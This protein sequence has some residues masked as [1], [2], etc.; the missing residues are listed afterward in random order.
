[1]KRKT[2][3]KEIWRSITHS[4]GRVLAIFGIVALGAGFLAGLSAASPTMKLTADLY[5][6]ETNYMDIRILSTL[7][8]TDEDIEALEAVQGVRA[9]MPSHQ[10]DLMVTVSQ[11]ENERVVRFA[12]LPDKMNEV[13]L[14]SGRLPE[15]E[16]ECV[17]NA[18]KLGAGGIQL[19]DEL[20]VL[21]D[22]LRH[23]TY[24]VVGLVNSAQYLSMSL[25]TT[26]KGNG[27]LNYIAYLLEGEF[28]QDVYTVAYVQAADTEGLSAFSEEYDAAIQ[29]I[30][31]ELEAVGEDRAQLRYDEMLS[32]AEDA[33][34]EAEDAYREEKEKAEKELA[35][36][37]EE[38][39][40]HEAD[41]AAGEE[42][43]AE[44]L[45]QIQDGSES[46]EEAW[47]LYRSGMADLK[48]SK[49]SGEAQFA[50]A[51]K[52]LV[53]SA[54]ELAEKKAEWEAQG[55]V[56]EAGAKELADAQAQ[57]AAAEQLLQEKSSELEEMRVM[58]DE[59]YQALEAMKGLIPDEEYEAQYAQWEAQANAFY[60]GQQEV[61][62]QHV[63]LQGQKAVLDAKAKELAEGQATYEVAGQQLAQAEEE[64]AAGQKELAAQKQN[65]AAQ[66]AAAERQLAEL[67]QTL[68]SNEEK[69]EESREKI[70]SSQ[71]EL[72]DARRQIK[73]GWKE[74]D[75]ARAEAD[76]AL[77]EAWEEIE[78]GRES[79]QDIPEPQWYV[80]DRNMDESFVSFSN[81]AE[82]MGTIATVFPWMFFIVAALV[83][84]TT[85]TRMVEEERQLIG[86]YK[87]LGFSTGWI[88]M[89]Y[90]IYAGAASL[91]GAVIGVIVGF[92]VLPR[93]VCS[94]YG[95]MYMLPKTE[96]RFYLGRA[97]IAGGTALL[98]TLLA[99]TSACLHSLKSK[100]AKLMQP[101][102]PKAG[103][104]I[105][106]ER[107]GPLWRHM[108]FIRKVTA[109]NL[110]R[111]K[112]RLFMTV[113]GIAGC[114]GL[115]VTGFGLKD[116]VMD[117]VENQ[118]H[119]V[120]AYD[121]MLGITDEAASRESLK[122][123]DMVGEYLY[124]YG[125]MAEIQSDTGSISA[126]LYVPEDEER[127][128][129]FINFRTRVGSHPVTFDSDH[130][131]ITEKMADRLEVAIGD[132]IK[133]QDVNGY[134]KAFIVGGITENY[135]QNY[136][137]LPR[138]YYEEDLGYELT[139]NQA[140]FKLADKGTDEPV[141]ELL[142]DRLKDAEGIST[143]QLLEDIIEPIEKMIQSLNLVVMVLI[144]SAGMLAFIVLYNLTN[145][146]ITERQREIATIKV[147]G[148]HP[149]EVGAYI[150]RETLA[151]TFIGCAIGL[152]FGIFMHRFVTTTVEVDMVMFGRTVHAI[153][154]LWSAIVTILFSV[155]V[156]FVMYFKL[157]KINMVESLKSVD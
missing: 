74:L 154:F 98:C 11:Q 26:T 8:L 55:P 16:D 67:Q 113:I 28:D 129:E 1:M 102:A 148:F 23:K 121:G 111:Y 131:V 114:T 76:E 45:Q 41:L 24:T 150:Y 64:L 30:V 97:I 14:L 122:N 78:K 31:D 44:G 21:E 82:R 142:R 50:A 72:E 110:F 58:L 141:G 119:K 79:L 61:A 17:V 29:V 96:I 75:K 62:K 93:V 12:G 20:T 125:R 95:L 140:L 124:V 87:A 66:I 81:D 136:V 73:D 4:M 51:E 139:Y 144:I 132:E 143:V 133:L 54:A 53:D 108:S 47:E 60:A 155:F 153:H 84:L 49:R 65:A 59:A 109:R 126:Y 77:A 115:L 134:N 22:G 39:L 89:K 57:L 128:T 6:E 19:G 152:V 68:L 42:E 86:T 127:L 33:I 106:L 120:D 147:L 38:L 18:G 146:N 112:K 101:A 104:R 2:F 92:Q 100:P 69:L 80:L 9:V 56:L 90:L 103:K 135:V 52:K 151:L 43:L 137:Y 15:A 116:S 40:Q 149:G 118:F 27:N 3:W 83:S 117:I 7:G 130:V 145:I 37:E 91:L 123:A 71:A 35:D 105:F 138:H 107:I 99:T 63:L 36:A 46:L 13:V 5:F 48:E 34:G 94:A 32:E 88:M 85:M 70:E 10:L 25:G 156:N 157:K